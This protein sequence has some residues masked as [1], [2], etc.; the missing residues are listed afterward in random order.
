MVV[1]PMVQPGGNDTMLGQWR[2]VLKQAEEA[3]RAGHFEEA[4]VLVHRP[5]V[6]DHKQVVSLRHRLAE[7]LIARASRRTDADD[8]AG[9]IAD[10]DLAQRH[11]APADLLATA[12]LKVAERAIREIQADLSAGDPCKVVE[13]LAKLAEH[14]ITSPDLRRI[15]ETAEA[16]KKALDDARRGEF[17]MALEELARTARLGGPSVESAVDTARQE[18]EHRRDAA[19]PRIERLYASL[20]LARW[21]ETLA[22]AESVLEFVP[23]HPAARQARSRA[24]QQIG[25]LSPSASLP[26]RVA[27]GPAPQVAV[28]KSPLV[29]PASP[30]KGGIMFLDSA[31][32]DRDPAKPSW[33]DAMLRRNGPSPVQPSIPGRSEGG[34]LGGRFLLWADVIGGFLVCLDD[35]IVLGR[36][37]ADSPADVPLLGDL[38]RKHATLVRDGDGYILKAHQDTYINGKR[39]EASALRNGDVIRLGATLELEFHQPSPVSS[40]AR[41]EIVSRHRLPMAVDAVILMAETCIVGPSPQ[42]HVPAPALEAPLVLYRQGASLWCRASGE[43]TVDGEERSSRSP[44]TLRSCVRGE[45]FSFSLEPMSPRPSSV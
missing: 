32:K 15:R 17:G 33:Q 41:L 27:A 16:W 26:G 23:D 10:L 18:I 11:G 31:D 45:G 38:S 44:L 20:G 6:H 24:W 35:E 43:F 39:I 29:P 34:R 30:A 8:T 28:A 37:G 40:T 1:I 12:R 13:R 42:A 14:Q 2:I 9:A 4:L 21:G 7:D 36:A 3:A 5:D 25:G 22:A 19:A